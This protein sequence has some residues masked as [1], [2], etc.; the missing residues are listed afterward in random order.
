MA[1][2]QLGLSRP[3]PINSMQSTPLR[4]TV[5]VLSTHSSEN[6]TEVRISSDLQ[7][8]GA[9]T[10]EVVA[11]PLAGF[12]GDLNTLGGGAAARTDARSSG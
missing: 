9:E 3:Y 12:L 4:S 10:Y 7:Y 2:P 6:P 11:N 8:P 5:G 1:E